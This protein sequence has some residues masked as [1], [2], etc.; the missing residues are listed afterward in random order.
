V[1]IAIQRSC[2]TPSSRCMK[3]HRARPRRWSTTRLYS[4]LSALRCGATT[5]RR[6]RRSATTTTTTTAADYYDCRTSP[7]WT[8]ARLAPFTGQCCRPAAGRRE[9]WPSS[10]FGRRAAAVTNWTRTDG[11]GTRTSSD[12]CSTFIPVTIQIYRFRR[13]VRALVILSHTVKTRI[14][15]FSRR[16]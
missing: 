3:C 9:R 12:C 8:A 10:A 2:G 6:W 14:G 15:Q 7:C 11:S 4:S 13:H 5:S 1:I 16:T